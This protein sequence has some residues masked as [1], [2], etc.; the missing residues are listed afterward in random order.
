M[1]E[2]MNTED[3]TIIN[4]GKE[5]QPTGEETIVSP[6]TK[7]NPAEDPE[8]IQDKEK[9]KYRVNKTAA[10]AAAVGGGIGSVVASAADRDNEEADEPVSED[11][12]EVAS[13]E[14]VA[15]QVQDEP[16]VNDEMSFGEAFA[17]AREAYGPD[18]V[19][20]WRGNSYHTNTREEMEAR[21]S[22]S[23][24]DYVEAHVESADNEDDVVEVSAD[25]VQVIGA[26][27]EEAII[28]DDD[29]SAY[30]AEVDEVYVEVYDDSMSDS[31]YEDSYMSDD[32]M[33]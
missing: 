17:A 7:T 14:V 26:D 20:E 11:Q 27:T 13:E 8:K 28:I 6:G 22:A 21:E 16:V 10:A 18:A 33:F 12:E 29:E 23:D 2:I 4:N 19:F 32:P 15:E 3:T 25:D 31:M 24:S 1:T 5:A 9:K 30:V